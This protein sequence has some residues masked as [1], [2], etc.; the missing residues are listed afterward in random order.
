MWN[1]SCYFVWNPGVSVF[2]TGRPSTNL[3]FGIKS[4]SWEHSCD[5]EY[6]QEFGKG[7]ILKYFL[8]QAVLPRNSDLIK[9]FSAYYIHKILP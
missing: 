4:V 1:E 5:K 9:I 7:K 8:L 3:D 2:C 6:F